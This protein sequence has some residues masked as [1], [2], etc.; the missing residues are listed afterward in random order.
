M[1][2]AFRRQNISRN[3]MVWSFI[4]FVI[5]AASIIML[6]VTVS[7]IIITES[8]GMRLVSYLAADLLFWVPVSLL[9]ITAPTSL[10]LCIASWWICKL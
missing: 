4:M 10:L 8:L 5:A 6:I 9:V 1:N 7:F 2:E 3:L